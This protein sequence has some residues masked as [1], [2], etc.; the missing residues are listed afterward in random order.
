ML[1]IANSCNDPYFNMALE[2][3]VIK[4]LDPTREYFMLWQNSPAVIVGRNQNTFAEV[5]LDYVRENHIAVVRRLSGGGAVYHDLGNINFTYVVDYNGYGRGMEQFTRGVITALARLGIKAQFS[6]RNDITIDGKKI[7]G[8]AQYL[9]QKR[10]L[11]HGT[12]LFD[13]DLTKLAQVLKPAKDKIESKGIK[14]IRSRVTNI[15]EHLGLDVSIQEFKQLLVECV[16]A[17]VG[18]AVR[19]YRLTPADEAQIEVLRKEKYATWDWNYGVSPAF[20]IQR[21]RRFDAGQ[22]EVRL[23]IEQG[24]IAAIRFYGDFLSLRDLSDV[25]ERLQGLPYRRDE[26]ELA[27]RKI[28]LKDYFGD[29]GLE[30]L[31][32]VIL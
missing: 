5:N 19:E 8:N 11:H 9:Y 31:L 10:L 3:Y 7:S 4:K 14:S 15:R 29:I 16:F 21:A 27:L 18:E 17:E 12:L 28:D 6:G 22:I 30:D 26:I 32:E 1:Y 24:R 13:S 25:E 20:A 2:E 23:G